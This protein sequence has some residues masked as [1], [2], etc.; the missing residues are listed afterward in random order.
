MVIWRAGAAAV[1]T[2]QADRHARAPDSDSV[3]QCTRGTDSL[4]AFLLGAEKYLPCL[5]MA[6]QK[7]LCTAMFRKVRAATN[8]GHGGMGL[9]AASV[10]DMEAVHAAMGT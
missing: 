5:S 6:Q 2:T 1:A 9:D 3:E 4:S 10:V 8:K 7:A